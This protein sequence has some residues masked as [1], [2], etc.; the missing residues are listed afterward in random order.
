MITKESFCMAINAIL[1]EH[2]NNSRLETALHNYLLDGHAVVKSSATYEALITLLKRELHDDV[3]FSTIEWW[4]FDK[5]DKYIYDD[6]HNIIADL[7][8]VED[9]YDYLVENFN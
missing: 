9:L 4:L 3:E 1:N 7:T 8:N 5:V 2:E 6:N